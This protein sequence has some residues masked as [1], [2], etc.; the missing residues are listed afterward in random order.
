MVVNVTDIVDIEVGDL[1]NGRALMGWNMISGLTPGTNACSQLGN[2]ESFHFLSQSTAGLLDSDTLTTLAARGSGTAT[3]V[4]SFR[5]PG[6]TASLGTLADSL[7]VIHINV[8]LT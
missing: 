3:N 2:D 5:D 4:V 6:F 8:N 7:R 1:S